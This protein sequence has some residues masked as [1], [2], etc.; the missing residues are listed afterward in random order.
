MNKSSLL[1]IACILSACTTGVSLES[2]DYNYL[3]NDNNSKVWLVNKVLVDNA[4][5]SPANTADKDI[6][7]FHT[8]LYV[9][10]I[11]LKDLTRKPPAKGDY[12]LNSKEKTLNIEFSNGDNWM[13]NLVYL[14]EDSILMEPAK[15][16]DFKMSIQL[17]PFPEL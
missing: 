8:S 5:V 1:I 4:V 9:D 17:K 10:Y 16:S 11:P 6:M 2:V 7:V 3:F 13:F 12:R 14:T 15:G